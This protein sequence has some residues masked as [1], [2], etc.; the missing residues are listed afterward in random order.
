MG[1]VGGMCPEGKVGGAW[2]WG[3]GSREGGGGGGGGQE[4]QGRWVANEL[5]QKDEEEPRGS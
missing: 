4:S 3:G 2:G 1:R 5:R